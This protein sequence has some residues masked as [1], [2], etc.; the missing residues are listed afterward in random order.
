[1]IVAAL[2]FTVILSRGDPAKDLGCDP[3]L[4]SG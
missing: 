1:M 2:I 3:S 4:R